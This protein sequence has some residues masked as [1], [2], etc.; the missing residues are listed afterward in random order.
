MPYLKEWIESIDTS[1]VKPKR[2]SLVESS[3]YFL[4]FNYT[5]LL[6]KI[7]KIED[8]L[9]IHGAVQSIDNIDPIMGHNNHQDIEVHKKGL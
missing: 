7:Y 6:E 9:H 5:D 4:S 2:L 1:I 8:V 3:D